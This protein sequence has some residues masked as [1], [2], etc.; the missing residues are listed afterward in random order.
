MT[1][2]YE[3]LEIEKN[4]GKDEIKAAFRKKARQLH[5]DVNKAPDAEEK[6]KELGKAYETLIDDQKRALYDQ[7]GED[8]L[9]NAGFGGGPFDGGFG[10]LNDIFSSF[11]EN[12][13][14]G[15]GFR[16]DPNAP[17]TGDSLRVDI[18]LDFK[19][20]AFGVDKEIKIDHLEICEE[21]NGS[22][23]K[24]GSQKVTCKTCGGQGRVQQTTRTAFGSF[25]QVTTC[26]TCKGKGQVIETPC[27]A[28]KGVGR[29]E[30]EKKIDVKIPAGV[31]NGSKIRLSNEGDAGKNGGMAGDLYIVIHVKP[32]E[33]FKRDGVNIYREIEISPA[34]AVLG[35][36]IDVETLD[37]IKNISI[38]S[39]IQSG[40]VVKLRGEGIPYIAKP[41]QKGDLILIVI[42]KTPVN[43]SNEEK[44]LYKK[45]YEIHSNTTK[46][47]GL[48]EKIKSSL[49]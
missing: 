49:S 17:Q 48:F 29:I 36:N 46:K 16:E 13:G 2:Y 21:C 45:L 43:I 10:D 12:F 37:G 5:P 15:G 6:F 44:Q 19:E 9:N 24:A 22:G 39:G 1:D 35:D 33:M 30:K 40:N 20:A 31:D 25:S 47:D 11:F 32:S 18:E 4:A 41:S 7:Y 42:V 23:A 38:P 27:P 3:I 8:G 14:F 34:Q 26:P 28:C